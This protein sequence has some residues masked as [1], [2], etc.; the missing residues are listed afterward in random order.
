MFRSLADG[1]E[2]FKS[3]GPNGAFELLLLVFSIKHWSGRN[4]IVKKIA[5]AVC[6]ARLGFGARI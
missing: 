2:V 6:C 3:L 5:N 4:N 1:D